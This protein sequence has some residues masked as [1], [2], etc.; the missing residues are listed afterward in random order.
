MTA[1]A[2]LKD[3]ENI[4]IQLK[5]VGNELK[6]RALKGVI[7]KEICALVKEYK[8]ELI[9]L[10]AKEDTSRED[11]SHAST[12]PHTPDSPHTPDLSDKEAGTRFIAST[13]PHPPAVSHTP[14]SPHT[15]DLS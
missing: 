5:L 12:V 13:V 6:I 14:D 4:H 15:P 10:L 3:L 7:T 11:A 9:E 2:L 8:T 1:Q